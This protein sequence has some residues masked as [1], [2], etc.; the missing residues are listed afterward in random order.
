MAAVVHLLGAAAPTSSVLPLGLPWLGAHFRIDALAAFFLAV[1][2]LGAF[3]ASLFALGYGRH[4]EAPT[5]VLPFYPAFLAGMRLLVEAA[6][7]AQAADKKSDQA[8]ANAAFS[9][10]EQKC[11]ECHTAFRDR[12]RV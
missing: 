8:R 11:A 4:E 12:R 2:D 7:R 10:C 1:V 9:A 3:A 6:L 5:R